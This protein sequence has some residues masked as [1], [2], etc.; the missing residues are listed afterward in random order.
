M[1]A[2]SRS[3]VG[4][5]R[6][7]K[8]PPRRYSF[9]QQ[10]S[11]L[12]AT[13][14][15]FHSHRHAII[16]EQEAPAGRCAHAS[17]LDQTER[18]PTS[19]LPPLPSRYFQD[20]GVGV[21][22]HAVEHGALTNRNAAFGWG[23]LAHQHAQKRG[24]TQSIAANDP[25]QVPG[26]NDRS[27]WLNNQRSPTKAPRPLVFTTVLL[28]WRWRDDEIHHQFRFRGVNGRHAVIFIEPRLLLV[29]RPRTPARTNSSLCRRKLCR[30]RSEFASTVSRM[31]LLSKK[32][33]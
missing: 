3:F 5:S 24:L 28:G 16:A 19:A 27:R 8:F 29:P 2:R 21:A 12:F 13:A 7:M 1:V 10:H 31:A 11:A 26:S 18:T 33:L 23:L 22:D 14:E 17:F 9:C 20:S 15:L 30:R 32:S 4:S 25:R 6:M